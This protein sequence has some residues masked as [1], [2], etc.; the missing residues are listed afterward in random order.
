MATHNLQ[1]TATDVVGPVVVTTLGV[2]NQ[3][4][5]FEIT[6]FTQLVATTASIVG[7]VWGL[8]N[9][10]KFTHYCYRHYFPKP[11]PKKDT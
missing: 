8:I 1:Q 3:P 5:F 4:A 6:S 10:G 7:V 9:I 11:T 2:T